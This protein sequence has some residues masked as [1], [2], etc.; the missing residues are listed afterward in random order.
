MSHSPNCRIVDEFSSTPESP[1]PFV[2]LRSVLA[3][4]IISGCAPTTGQHGVISPKT[5]SSAISPAGTH[6]PPHAQFD[7]RQVRPHVSEEKQSKET[8]ETFNA[9]CQATGDF[10]ITPENNLLME[11][12]CIKHNARFDTF[13]AEDLELS[14][15]PSYASDIP[16]SPFENRAHISIKRNRDQVTLILSFSNKR[17]NPQQ[18]ELPELK[19]GKYGYS[20]SDYVPDDMIP[21]NYPLTAE[22]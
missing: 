18:I 5:A 6:Q 17:G 7:T 2:L 1:K 8:K 3:G 13:R 9:V 14:S 21:I 16:L 10:N 11:V 15:N 4:L 22:Q 12:M 20:F 19:G